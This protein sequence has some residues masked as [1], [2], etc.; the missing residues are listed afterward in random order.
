MVSIGLTAPESNIAMIIISLAV[1]ELL[2]KKLRVLKAA[3]PIT[4]Q[5]CHY[6]LLMVMMCFFRFGGAALCDML[7][8]RYQQIKS[9]ILWICREIFCPRR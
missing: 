2:L 7:H 5:N 6:P 8:L 9:Y 3:K 4:L 1:N